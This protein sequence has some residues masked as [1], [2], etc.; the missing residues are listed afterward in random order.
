MT[1]AI[2]V[3]HGIGQQRPL[4][5]QKE[6]VRAIR[7]ECITQNISFSLGKTDDTTCKVLVN[8]AELDI[9][10]VFW[11]DHTENRI[12][13]LESLYFIGELYTKGILVL[14]NYKKYLTKSM[15]G[16][17]KQLKISLLTILK[18]SS[19]VLVIILG[20]MGLITFLP[21]I[22][23][24]TLFPI[25]IYM[26]DNIL[27]KYIGDFAAY[28]IATNR[29]FRKYSA[30]RG[31]IQTRCETILTKAFNEHENVI[32]VSHSLG[33]VIAYDCLNNIL[34]KGPLTNFHSFVTVGS[35][36]DKIEFLS[37]NKT[38]NKPFPMTTSYT[39]RSNNW[40]NIY[41]HFDPVG[42]SLDYFDSV[43]FVGNDKKIKNIKDDKS[44]IFPITAHTG[45]FKRA[46]FKKILLDLIMDPIV[47]VLVIEPE[48]DK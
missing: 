15:F 16:T 7:E 20:L 45:Y 29:T 27:K 26:L 3:V 31:S 41:T 38:N 24:L 25:L 22:L 44:P 36:L 30:V 8:G 1:T 32:V 21:T 42:G 43:D 14:F 40:I 46:T 12:S 11:A 48:S 10:E 33:S 23:L 18:F 9:I 47:K 2:V 34:D 17:E 5:T 13:G 19:L 28:S 37:N 35:P 6:I 4:Q 39:L